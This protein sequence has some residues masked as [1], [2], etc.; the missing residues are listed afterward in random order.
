M[1]MDSTEFAKLTKKSAEESSDESADTPPPK[2]EENAAATDGKKDSDGGVN[3]R[4]RKGRTPV[5]NLPPVTKRQ[6]A[7]RET[8]GVAAAT[9]EVVKKKRGRPRKNP[10][11]VNGDD[12]V[13]SQDEGGDAKVEDSQ[14]TT[15]EASEPSAKRRALGRPRRGT[16]SDAEGRDQE[17][18][19]E[20]DSATGKEGSKSGLNI[21]YPDP[22]DPAIVDLAETDPTEIVKRKPGRPKKR[23]RS[24]L[25]GILEVEP[26]DGIEFTDEG[27]KPPQQE[28]TEQSSGV[29]SL[30]TELVKKVNVQ[31]FKMSP[32]NTVM[33]RNSPVKVIME[34]PLVIAPAPEEE[35]SAVVKEL[36]FNGAEN[37][38]EDE[39]LIPSSQ[40]QQEVCENRNVILPLSRPCT[41]CVRSLTVCTEEGRP[42]LLKIR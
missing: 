13:M 6:S 18:A 28:D 35:V 36:K 14:K 19:Q 4:R 25:G 9:P 23:P 33:A 29:L 8:P 12:D 27:D 26:K 22:N 30:Q 2:E 38:E 11:K 17:S 37:E 1:A 41:Y 5:K 3:P 15:E 31:A 24:D 42:Q 7:N 10:P 34:E 21:E 39:E 32:K 40:N 16:A 20:K